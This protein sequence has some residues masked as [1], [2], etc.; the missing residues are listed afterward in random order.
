MSKKTSIGGQALIE[1]I[2]MKGPQKTALAVRL[3]D[4]EI[5]VSF[6]S[7]KT[8]KDKLPFL[9]APV[10]RGV[11]NFIE[12][13]L[14]GYKA[15]MLSADK[16]G[17][18]ELEEEQKEGEERKEPEKLS[19]AVMNVL[20]VIAAVLGVALAVVL[21]MLVPRLVVGGIDLLF[22][23]SMP[24]FLRALIE[25]LIKMAVFVCYVWAV[26]FMKD[27]RRVFMYHGAEHKTIFC[28]EAGLP[29]TVENVRK[30]KRFHPRCGTSF[31]I[32]MI[33]V[34]FVFSTVVQLLFRGVYDNVVF[35]VLAKILM[36]PFICG[37]GYELLKICGRHDN[38]LTR[39]I[40]APGLWLQRITTQEP[41]DD[42]LE[43]AIAAV[44]EV[45][46]E[47]P[48]DDRW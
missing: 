32:L 45:I 24:S 13:M 1:G 10:L 5:D 8:I 37:V 47:N 22:G 43:I 14:T 46:P 38:L 11:V 21:F 31:M 16:S 6:M 29:L 26:S 2:M 28:Y 48:D 35:W 44:N 36:L 20:M 39:I 12:S 40:A 19:G 17:F 25:Q 4:G 18:T 30:Q 7:E 33:I 3:P 9:K 15:L 34:G 41:E 23:D 27:I 42:M